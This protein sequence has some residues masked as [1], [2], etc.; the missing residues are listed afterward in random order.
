[1]DVNY[2]ICL[3]LQEKCKT[4]FYHN[5]DY[6][7]FEKGI[8]NYLEFA[9]EVCNKYYKHT[10]PHNYFVKWLETGKWNEENFVVVHTTFLT[11]IEILDI[12]LQYLYDFQKQ[13]KLKYEEECNT[14]SVFIGEGVF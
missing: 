4:W 2:E 10:P 9:E 13:F 3:E 8:Q 6:N 11:T 5:F 7:N 14:I 12:L 1:M